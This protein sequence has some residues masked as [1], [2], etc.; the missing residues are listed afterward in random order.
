MSKSIFNAGS[1]NLAYVARTMFLHRIL[2]DLGCLI[3]TGKDKK[4][5]FHSLS[6]AILI[7]IWR[8]VVATVKTFVHLQKVSM[9]YVLLCIITYCYVL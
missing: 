9:N 1:L 2:I 7:S 8:F 3:R 4:N 5:K 6:I